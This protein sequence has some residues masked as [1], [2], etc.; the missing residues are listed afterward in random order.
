MRWFGFV[1]DPTEGGS[2]LDTLETLA[3]PVPTIF[4]P[5][6]TGTVDPALKPIDRKDEVR[7]RRANTAPVSFAS[8]P[9]L[10]FEARAYPK[11]L[12]PMVR[13]ALGGTIS[14][15][16]TAPAAISSTVGPIQSGSLPA[17]I[18]WLLREGQLDRVTGAVVSEIEMN[19]PV[20]GE[21]TMK[22]TADCLYRDVDHTESATDPNGEPALALPTASYTGYE[23]TFM[24][25]D[26]T[27]FRGPEAGVE[28]PNLAG[29]TLTFNNGLIEDFRSRFRPNHNIDSR[30]IDEVEHKLWYP[31]RH[32]IGAQ[33]VTGKLDLS[34]VDPDAELKS[35]FTHAE[36][37]V[38][39]IAAGPLGTTP[40]ADE[41][42]RLTLYK[43]APTGGGAEPIVREGDQVSSFEFE[44]FLD[45]GL[46]KDFETTFVGAT[47][48][49]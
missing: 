5:V 30:I 32:V 4:V 20:E 17:F 47:A 26:A 14:K 31:N 43:H 25:R 13:K 6:T 24:L 12:R 19:F 44:G 21:G 7:G 48:L 2:K 34:E 41:M 1:D 16:G 49:T 38:F 9:K 29:L 15:S 37:L 45:D 10:T 23:D 46:G 8:E 18:G 35:L 36:K 28:I 22:L 3:I 11:L 27:A 42:M 33:A 40:P 39:E